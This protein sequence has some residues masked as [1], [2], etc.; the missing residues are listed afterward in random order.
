MGVPILLS[1]PEGEAT[2]LIRQTGAGVCVPPEDPR[3]LAQAIEAL[4]DAPEALNV[5]RKLARQAASQFSRDTL[6]EH[7]TVAFGRTT[8]AP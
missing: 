2:Q 7:M 1:A 8:E 4:A 5:L 3:Q 6:A